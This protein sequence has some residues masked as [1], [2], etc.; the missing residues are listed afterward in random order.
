MRAAIAEGQ[1]YELELE[2]TTAK[3]ARKWVRTIGLPVLEDGRV[4]RV[5]GAIQDI[6]TRKL[7]EREARRREAMLDTVFQVLPDLFFLMDADGTILDYRASRSGDLYVSPEHF[8]GR[9]MGDVLPPAAA[10]IFERNLALA[11]SEHRLIT[12]EYDLHMPDGNRRFEAR[13]NHLP[14]TAQLIAVVRDMTERTRTEAALEAQRRET[15]L[16]ATLLE[17]SRQPMAVGFPDGR[18]GRV[19]QAFLDLIGHSREEINQIDWGRDLTPPEWL[20]VELAALEQ[21]HR[22]GRPVRYEK[23]YVRKDGQRI[24]VELYVHELKDASGAV[25]YYYAFV[26][27]I[28]E[29]KRAEL[30]LRESESRYRHLFEHNPAP[31]LIY[32]RG[33]LHL[34]SVNESFLDHYGYS[35][36]EAEAL[37]LTD[38]YPPEERQPIVDLAARLSGLAYV[39]EWHHLKKDG[40]V[41]TIEARSHDLD[42]QGRSARVAVVTDITERKRIED[43]VHRLNAELEERVLGAHR[44][45]GRHQQGAGDLY[46]FGLA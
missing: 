42:Y 28:T 8:L 44:R 13:L 1:P 7:A 3:G 15:D 16:L 23:E 22:T 39:G 41:I 9:R 14:D 43:A 12:Y 17:R 25:D 19:N 38:L 33:S 37:R 29:R 21:T 26:T 18:L 24:P 30:A 31:M 36:E 5:Q 35:R 40:A 2:M 4:V 6:T 46:L 11:A 27:D 32:E 20:D 34:L 10:E 45:A